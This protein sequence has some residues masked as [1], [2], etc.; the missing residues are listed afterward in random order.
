[1][2]G[3]RVLCSVLSWSNVSHRFS[4]RLAKQVLSCR[5][6]STSQANYCG[7]FV[8]EHS[9][10][11]SQEQAN[12]LI[13]RLRRDE[14][15]LLK[16]AIQHYESHADEVEFQGLLIVRPPLSLRQRIRRVCVNIF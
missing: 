14:I 15:H 13:R 2:S 7:K 6:L 8:T 3:K 4:Q 1:M 16:T 12:D 9:E 5:A 11:V 10:L